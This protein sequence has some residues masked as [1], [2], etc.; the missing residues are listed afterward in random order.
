MGRKRTGSWQ[1]LYLCIAL[2]I[3]LVVSGCASYK[4]NVETGAT[5]VNGPHWRLLNNDG[6]HGDQ[7]N[8]HGSANMPQTAEVLFNT[9]LSYADPRDPRKDYTK[10]VIVFKKLIQA[11]PN[12]VW[13]D[14]SHILL[15]ILQENTRLRKQSVDSQQE[16]TRLRKQSVDS[17]QEN[18]RLKQIIE[19]SKN[20]DIEIEQKKRESIK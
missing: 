8:P 15:D 3:C 4:E 2:L 9:G 16:N 20:V 6:A 14:R 18:T 12:G 7:K 13:A 1:H 11:Y 19:Q 10:S 17:Q 5:Q